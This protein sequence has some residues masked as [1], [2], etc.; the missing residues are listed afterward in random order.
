MQLYLER[1]SILD[2]AAKMA[3]LQVEHTYYKHEDLALATH[4]AHCFNLKWGD[5]GNLH[6]AALGKPT[7]QKGHVHPGAASGYPSVTAEEMSAHRAA[8]DMEELVAFVFKHGDATGKTRAL[9]CSVFH[10]ATHDRYYQARDMFLISHVQDIVDKVDISTQV[11][12]NRALVTMGVAAF[13]KGL[14]QQTHDHL[15]NICSGRIKE[16]LAQATSRWNPLQDTAQ[17]QERKAERRRQV[18]YHMHINTDMLESCHLC[19]AMLLELPLMAN[20]NSNPYPVS[21]LFRKY[22]THYTRQ[23]FTGPPENVRDNV[24]CASKAI[25]AGN[26]KKG[27]QLILGLEA[28]TVVPGDKAVIKDALR[29][30]VVEMALRIFLLTAGRHYESVDISH[31]MDLFEMEAED[32]RRVISV[33]LSRKEV[34]GAWAKEGTVLVHYN[35]Q[36]SS[37]QSVTKQ[38]AEK[39]AQLVE[40]NERLLFQLSG[41]TAGFMH[42]MHKDDQWQGNGNKW[43]NGDARG[44]NNARGWRGS[45]ANTVH[46]FGG[47][48]QGTRSGGNKGAPKKNVWAAG[49]GSSNAYNKY[50]NKGAAGQNKSAPNRY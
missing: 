31:I 19:S 36:P 11:L 8:I 12:Y 46:K 23:V 5:Y 14:I 34:S 25:L 42:S 26:W 38:V 43:G 32:V 22:L 17:E 30:K 39:V 33:M 27:L 40:G 16:L 6:P 3:L 10:H 41:G 35:V 50:T 21:K 18:P 44:K 45:G 13:K 4:K 20:P 47:R 15:S 1:K 2:S 49:K 24:M 29:T 28:W 48:P 7:S 9:L 37:L